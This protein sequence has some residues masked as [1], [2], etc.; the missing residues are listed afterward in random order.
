MSMTFQITLNDTYA[1]HIEG[2][3]SEWG[4]PIEQAVLLILSIAF[5]DK[6]MMTTFAQIRETMTTL[7]TAPAVIRD[8]CAQIMG[9]ALA[10]E[11]AGQDFSDALAELVDLVDPDDCEWTPNV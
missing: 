8:Q 2:V 1:T 9:H 3:S 5:G 10:G 7:K 6:K 11:L 4:I